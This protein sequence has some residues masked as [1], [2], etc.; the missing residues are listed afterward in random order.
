MK[1]DL[2]P[3]PFTKSNSKWS[4]DLNRKAKTVKYFKII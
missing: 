3:T 1:M 4:K 2:Y